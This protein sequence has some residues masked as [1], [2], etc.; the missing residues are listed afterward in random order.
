[1]PA[2]MVNANVEELNS[3]YLK[4][5]KEVV[6]ALQKENYFNEARNFAQIAGISSEEVLINEWSVKAKVNKE[7]AVFWTNV[8]IP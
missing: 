4:L 7:S 1:M 2:I 3:E 6:F 8:G 5:T